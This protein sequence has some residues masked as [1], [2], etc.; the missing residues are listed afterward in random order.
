MLG[1]RREAGQEVPGAV[2]AG[3]HT[4]QL[5]PRNGAQNSYSAI[6]WDEISEEQHEVMTRHL[7]SQADPTWKEMYK[8]MYNHQL[9]YDHQLSTFLADAKTTLNNMRDKVWAATIA[10]AM[11]KTSSILSCRLMFLALC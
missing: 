9:D 4:P 7:C 11:S 8:V 3:G 10:L 6:L 1:T 2:G 5:Y